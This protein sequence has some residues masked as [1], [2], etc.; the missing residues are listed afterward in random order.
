MSIT[1]FMASMLVIVRLSSMVADQ[2]LV[3]IVGAF[4]FLA[5]KFGV[6]RL[7][8]RFTVHRGLIHSIPFAVLCGEIAFLLVP[9]TTPARTLKAIALALGM[10]SHLLLDEIFSLQTTSGT[11]KVKKSFGTAL[12]FIRLKHMELT[13]ILYG[14][15]AVATYCS[16][17]QPAFVSE[18]LDRNLDRFANLSIQSVMHLN[19]VSQQTQ[20]QLNNTT[21]LSQRFGINFG[22]YSAADAQSN[23]TQSNT[24]AG[25]PAQNGE[26]ANLAAVPEETTAERKSWRQRIA[27]SIVENLTPGGNP[28]LQQALQQPSQRETSST[29]LIAISPQ[30]LPSSINVPLPGRTSSSQNIPSYPPVV[31]SGNLPGNPSGNLPPNGM[32]SGNIPIIGTSLLP[33]PHNI[34]L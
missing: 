29:P 27:S 18:A 30:P 31:P 28:D 24:D 16:F 17:F 26:P 21:N 20:Q 1:S 7:V 25:S 3:A 12:K 6:G 14:L 8:K 4:V 2:E 15:I 19:M 33:S 32:P 11:L 9:G 23:G 5:V 22:Q 13:G 10:L 34:S